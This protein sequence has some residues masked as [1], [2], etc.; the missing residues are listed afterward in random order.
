MFLH[1]SNLTRSLVDHY[2]KTK[3]SHKFV[4]KDD[5]TI[6]LRME[7]PGFTEDTL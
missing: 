6:S 4:Q 5:G 7:V 1:S 2:H 3:F